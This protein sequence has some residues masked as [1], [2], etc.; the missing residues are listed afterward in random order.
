MS[1][2]A[3]EPLVDDAF[4]VVFPPE[5]PIGERS[6]ITWRDL[7]AYP[8]VLLSPSSSARSQFDQALGLTP[9]PS[10]LHYDVTHIT[11]AVVLVKQGLVIAV[12]PKLPLR[13]MPLGTVQSKPINA[14]STQRRN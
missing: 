4:C 6:S 1:D 9:A 2:M 10:L 12:L 7:T 14:V 8:L 5:H 3:F 13:V 11:T